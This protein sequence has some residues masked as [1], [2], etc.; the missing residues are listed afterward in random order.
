MPTGRLSLLVIST[1][2]LWAL[3]CAGR[4]KALFGAVVTSLVFGVASALSP[5]YW[6]YAVLR[7]FTGA[8]YTGGLGR[9]APSVARSM[10]IAQLLGGN[11]W[12]QSSSSLEWLYLFCRLWQQR[13]RH[14]LLRAGGGAGRA[15]LAGHLRHLPGG[16][17]L[18]CTAPQ[19][20]M[21]CI[22]NC[23][24]GERLAGVRVFLIVN[25]P[26]RHI[27]LQGCAFT[28]GACLLAPMAALVRPWR[29]LLVFA[30]LPMAAYLLL[31]PAVH[32]SPRW[33]L[34]AGRKVGDSGLGFE[35][36][37]Q[38]S[39]AAASARRLA[40]LPA[41]ILPLSNCLLLLPARP[42]H[43]KASWWKLTRV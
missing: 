12:L 4:R 6:W 10:V 26:G 36:V 23:V 27:P 24:L 40:L 34:V 22:P 39:V 11:G 18:L 25:R 14:H 31:W 32:E 41:L 1:Q 2:Q 19:P 13:D 7:A 9:A 43:L 16:L 3:L 42:M 35:V 5:D 8:W 20:Q 30:S 21:D 17:L 29:P 38:S 15:L 33:L 28:V 37:P